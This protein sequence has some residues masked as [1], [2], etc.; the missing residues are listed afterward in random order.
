MKAN[1]DKCQFITSDRN[2]VI[3]VENDQI[4]NS[5][6][7]KLFGIKKIDHKLTFNA[8]I[9]EI[10]KKTGQKTNPLSKVIPYMDIKKR[11]TLLNTF[12]FRSLTIA[13]NIDVSQSRKI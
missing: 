5:K 9:D 11:R 1:P 12:L 10:Y 3:N 8:H 7:E 2:L 4:T 6:C 13:S